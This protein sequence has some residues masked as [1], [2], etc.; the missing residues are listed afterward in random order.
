MLITCPECETSFSIPTNA[1]GEKGRKVKCSSCSHVWFQAP[2]EFDKQKLNDLLDTKKKEPAKQE[3]KK[4]QLPIKVSKKAIYGLSSSLVLFLILGVGFFYLN[5]EGVIPNHDGLRFSNFSSSSEIVDNR[6][7]FYMKGELINITSEPIKVPPIH[8]SVLSKGGRVMT[9]AE[10]LP[11][12]DVVPP[13]SRVEFSPEITQVSGHA[14][15]IS[16]SFANWAESIFE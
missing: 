11:K 3:F 8:V 9:E 10:M 15:R 4:D 16:L 13:H 2:V 6:Y 7:D 5:M 14:D 12:I 1:L